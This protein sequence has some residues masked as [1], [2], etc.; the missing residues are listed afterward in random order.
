[1][2]NLVKV[3][4]V[5]NKIWV[6]V[7]ASIPFH[8]RKDVCKSVR[9]AK[10]NPTKK[11]WTYPLQWAVCLEI[12]EKIAK[13]LGLDLDIGPNLTKWAKIEKER[14]Q[15]IPS[16]RSLE[17]VPL[18]R[19]E[20]SHPKL[21][22]AV[23]NRPFQ[24][25]GIAF[26]A[27]NRACLI[28]DEPGLGKTLQ[29]IGAVI[30]ADLRGMIL[31]VAPKTAGLVT[32]PHELA[33]WAPGETVVNL[34]GL[35]K[36]SPREKTR[37]E[38]IYAKGNDG[39][40]ERD[41]YT[42][43][44]IIE[45]TITHTEMSP[46][47]A[48]VSQKLF[49]KSTFGKMPS[50]RTWVITSP[51]WVRAKA[52]VDE[53]N[54]YQRDENGDKII[55]TA[56]PEIF[57]KEW[58]AVIVDESHEML[59]ANTANKKKWTQTRTGMSLL[60]IQ[61]QG[62]KLAMSGTPTRGKNQNFWGTLNWLRPDL[63]SSYWKWAE[64]WFSMFEDEAG[65]REMGSVANAQA[66]YDELAEV[67]IRR[68][69][70][71]VAADLPAKLYGGT[72]LNPDDEHSP[73][74]VWLE[75]DG[76]Q[77]SS[78]QEMVK[79]GAVD[80]QG[81]SLIA[82]GILSEWMRLKQLSSANAYY[83]GEELIPNPKES[84]KFE[85]L[86]EFLDERGISGKPFGDSKVVVASQFA[87]LVNSYAAELVSMGI[88]VHVLTGGTKPQDR[89]RMQAEWQAE[90]GPRVFLLSTK[91]GG[92]SLTLD[93]ADDVVILDETWIPDDQLQVE[94]RAHRISRPDHQVSIWYVRT[95]DS[96]EE[97]I[98]A[99]TGGREADMRLVMDATRGVDIRKKIWD[100]TKEKANV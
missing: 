59:I 49:P 24:T 52:E 98:A 57:E 5:G 63:Y 26:T 66:F 87:K 84:N 90:G 38:V 41:S 83:Q 9:G 28:G 69:K 12:R 25:V 88:P 92:V 16:V 62:I 6:T 100:Y 27:H 37:T 20:K 13:E 17:R 14:Q 56:L 2:T 74:G 29:A 1:M 30:E 32:W 10:W 15:H 45:K 64:K 72:P 36:L 82:N 68:T 79:N 97:A 73:V 23:N 65:N 31:I 58:A 55:K 44:R 85:W 21:F 81:G 7:P 76:K 50:K 93:A 80:L 78:Y 60:P 22:N 53:K 70:G 94:D 67:M 86:V 96:I 47:E 54:N 51:Y 71:E 40:W 4:M 19:M 11:V 42:G 18:P 46:R 34:A 8:W 99:V 35:S 77:K 39:E 91:A 48:Y 61:D 33:M 3:E 75:M 89:I 95:L 43:Q